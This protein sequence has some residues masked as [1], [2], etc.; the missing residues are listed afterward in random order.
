ME[1][2]Y[3]IRLFSFKYFNLVLFIMRFASKLNTFSLL[4]FFVGTF[5]SAIVLNANGDVHI[6]LQGKGFREL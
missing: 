2:A 5:F 6:T 1:T 3:F 4:D